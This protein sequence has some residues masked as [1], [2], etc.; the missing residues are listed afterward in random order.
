MRFLLEVSRWKVDMGRPAGHVR[1]GAAGRCVEGTLRD[2]GRK[3]RMNQGSVRARRPGFVPGPCARPARR[4]DICPVLGQQ[5]AFPDGRGRRRWTSVSSA[6]DR[7]R[8][9]PCRGLY[10]GRCLAGP[11]AL[12]PLDC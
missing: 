12:Q 10:G 4:A 11:A 9:M 1:H 2:D 7:V 6:A 8:S 3:T 5:P